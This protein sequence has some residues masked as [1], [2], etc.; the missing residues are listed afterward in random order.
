MCDG[1][2]SARPCSEIRA[3]RQQ[4][5]W[6]LPL[7]TVQ[8]KSLRLQPLQLILASLNSRPGSA[9]NCTTRP[10]QGGPPTK[11]HTY[12][13]VGGRLHS[14]HKATLHLHKCSHS[15]VRHLLAMW[16][17]SRSWEKPR[18]V[19]AD[20]STASVCSALLPGHGLAQHGWLKHGPAPPRHTGR[21]PLGLG[22][23]QGQH[24]QLCLASPSPCPPLWT[25]SLRGPG[26]SQRVALE[27]RGWSTG[28]EG[29]F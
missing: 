3:S 16:S 2:S 29:H 13:G 15:L 14:G 20:A 5:P 19:S 28:S 23:A 8:H 18:A 11:A 24:L 9:G 7:L 4:S 21:S 22:K 1:A 27:P 10:G 12:A 25:A 17:W 6:L 26:S